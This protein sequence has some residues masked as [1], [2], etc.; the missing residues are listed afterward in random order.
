[1][2]KNTIDIAYEV[3]TIKC[4]FALKGFGFI[5]RSKGKDLFFFYKDVVAEE[6]IL[7]G[8]TVRFQVEMN[9]RGRGPRALNVE[10]IG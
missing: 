6:H 4:F 8:V 3:G 10:R 2:N 5:T 7:E 1:M 9:D